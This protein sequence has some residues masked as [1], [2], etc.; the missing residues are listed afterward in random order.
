MCWSLVFNPAIRRHQVVPLYSQAFGS[1]GAVVAWFRTAMAVQH[2]MTEVFGLP[3]MVYVDDCFWIAPSFEGQNM[4]T[5]GWTQCVCE[6][7]VEYLL[8][9]ALDPNKTQV[10]ER[11]TLLGLELQFGAKES[12]WILNPDK[13]AEW[14]QDIKTYLLQN[15]LLP[16]EA[17]K[18]CGR[19][20]F[21]NCYVFG[22]LG[23]ALI[24]PIIWRQCQT[25]GGFSL[26]K[27]LRY[28]L[29]CFQRA[30]EEKWE[31]KLPY[32]SIK[33]LGKRWFTLTPSHM[34]Q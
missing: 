23:R 3:V 11:L 27:R 19:L 26:T 8:G 9:W 22:K 13:A 18:L 1:L 33:L 21:L 31:R 2:I 15:R 5:A 32:E 28:A 25:F 34:A 6:Y 7:V 24:R 4:P 14:A 10:N 30:L 16:A 20:A 12:T 17:S 29:R